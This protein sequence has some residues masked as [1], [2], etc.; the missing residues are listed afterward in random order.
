MPKKKD[1]MEERLRGLGAKLDDILAHAERTKDYATKINLEEL[2]RQKDEVERKLVALKKP[3]REA[4][5]EIQAGLNT[6][7]KDVRKSVGRAKA[8]FKK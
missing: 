7:W 5:S 8:K 3:A 6:A 2:K 4:I 1:S